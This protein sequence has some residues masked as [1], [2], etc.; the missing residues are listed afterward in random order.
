MRRSRWL[1]AGSLSR[2]RH[3]SDRGRAYGETGA[4]LRPGQGEVARLLPDRADGRA[5]HDVSLLVHPDAPEAEGRRHVTLGVGRRL[6]CF[7]RLHEA[8]ASRTQPAA[9]TKRLRLVQQGGDVDA[10][11]VPA[12]IGGA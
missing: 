10:S 3:R 4:L 2:S 12:T 9:A 11:S 8:V 6:S 7:G 5:C 1:T